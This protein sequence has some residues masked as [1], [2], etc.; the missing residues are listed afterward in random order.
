MRKKSENYPSA[1][2][3][4]KAL[5]DRIMEKFSRRRDMEEKT[6]I[7]GITGLGLLFVPESRAKELAE[8]NKALLTA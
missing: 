7:Y 6:I 4:T 5:D 8:G 2:A 1:T 3:S